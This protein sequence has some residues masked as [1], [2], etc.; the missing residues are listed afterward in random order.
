[1]SEKSKS[2]GS[3]LR[4]LGGGSVRVVTTRQDWETRQ[5]GKG[6]QTGYAV[7]LS[8][9]SFQAE[10]YRES[11]PDSDIWDFVVQEGPERF[12]VYLGGDEIF[13][14]YVPSAVL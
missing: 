10:S 9:V 11:S 6:D 1:M 12:H 7:G 2:K 14:L 3:V 4:E 5:I 8:L 13:L